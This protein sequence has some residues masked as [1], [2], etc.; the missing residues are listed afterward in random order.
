[1]LDIAVGVACDAR[2]VC[3][4]ERE[5]YAAGILATRMEDQAMDEAPIWS[6]LTTF[7]GAAWRG[8]VDC[9]TAG[10]PC[11]PHSVAGKRAGLN[12]ERW[13]WDYSARIIRDV[14]PWLVYLEN[15]PGLIN[16]GG[17]AACLKSLA[18]MGFDAEYGCLSAGAVGASHKRERIFI[19]AFKPG[20]GFRI[21]RQ[22]S[23]GGRELADASRHERHRSNR[24][25]G[26]GWGICETGGELAYAERQPG[27]AEQFNDAR[28]RTAGPAQN[29]SV[30]GAGGD[31]D[32]ANTEGRRGGLGQWPQQPRRAEIESAGDVVDNPTSARCD[33]KGVGSGADIGGGECLSGAGCADMGHAE[34]QQ[35]HG[36]L[37]ARGWRGG[38]K[39]ANSDVA[40]TSSPRPQGS[41]QRGARNTDGGGQETHGSTSQLCGIFAPGP[42][43]PRWADIIERWPHL[44][45]ALEPGFCQLVDGQSVVVDEFRADQLRAIGN[46]V[47][48]TAAAAAFTV[49]ARRAGVM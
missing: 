46:G 3:Y 18:E 41:E 30:S 39:N 32:A 29:E 24:E 5:A 15:V 16:T 34:C 31:S 36:G 20:R 19:L 25:G 35:Q 9:I 33:G 4:V 17:L 27:G 26:S 11:Q 44:A 42:G 28:E 49:L 14:E 8:T 7:A 40:N 38:L 43:D 47:V 21:V 10:F 6:D 13:L 1:M 23:G 37:E 22:P 2:T 45:P 48:A 12:D